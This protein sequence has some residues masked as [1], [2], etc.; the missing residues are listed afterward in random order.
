MLHYTV[1]QITNNIMCFNQYEE[2]FIPDYLAD[3]RLDKAIATLFPRYSRNRIKKWLMDGKILVNDC[4]AA[5]DQKTY[6][7][8]KIKICTD[9]DIMQ[10][11]A[12]HLAEKIDLNIVYENK[13]ILVINKQANLVVHPAAGNWHGTL[14]NGLLYHYPKTA[15]QLPRAGIIH[16]LDKNTSGLMVIAKTFEAQNNLVVQMQKRLIKRKYL[17]FVWGI[18]PHQGTI[19]SPIGRDKTHRHRMTTLPIGFGRQAKTYF[20]LLSI[21]NLQNE[22][23][24]LISCDLETGRTHQ[25]RTHL[26][27]IGHPLIGDPIYSRK[28]IR[29]TKHLECIPNKSSL[30]NPQ[31]KQNLLQLPIS[32]QALHAWKLG[33][34]DP[35]TS[36]WSEWQSDVPHDIQML[37]ASANIHLPSK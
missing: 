28:N 37:A 35:S 29:N 2:L 18:T 19:D 23:V 5:P 34:Q 32:R 17:A 13:S 11:E 8:N 14:L 10:E 7:N 26:E 1:N 15:T 16:R 20:H 12:M 22:P 6:K 21:G 33:L 3:I 9:Q 30:P 25:I 27:S 4:Q 31:K 24:S 36:V